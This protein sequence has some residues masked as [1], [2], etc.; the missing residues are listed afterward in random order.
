MG[1]TIPFQRFQEA[2][3][4]PSGCRSRSP[5]CGCAVPGWRIRTLLPAMLVGLAGSLWRATQE[6]IFNFFQLARTLLSVRKRPILRAVGKWRPTLTYPC[7]VFVALYRANGGFQGY[8][9]SREAPPDC[10]G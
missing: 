9:C 4:G 10:C 5:I 2:A 6:R 7:A 1:G 3:S 8:L